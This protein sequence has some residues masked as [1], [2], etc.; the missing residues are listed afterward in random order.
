MYSATS[1]CGLFAFRCAVALVCPRIAATRQAMRRYYRWPDYG[2][3]SS[4]CGARPLRGENRSLSK[5]CNS[6]KMRRFTVPQCGN[7]TVS[8]AQDHLDRAPES[9]LAI[10]AHTAPSDCGISLKDWPDAD[11]AVL[12]VGC[13]LCGTPCRDDSALPTSCMTDKLCFSCRGPKPDV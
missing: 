6:E 8:I 12:Q 10:A 1:R 3:S 5:T 11:A 2:L 13:C 4:S 7:F 9:V